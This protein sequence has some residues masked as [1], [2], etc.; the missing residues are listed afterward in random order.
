MKK[1]SL[2]NSDGLEPTDKV[3][4]HGGSAFREPQVKVLLA[5][6]TYKN[7]K[8]SGSTGRSAAAASL[9]DVAPTVLEMAG[10]PQAPAD[11]MSLA[12]V[13]SGAEE[14]HDGRIRYVESSFFPAA[15]NAVRIDEGEV[16][17]ETARM[18]RFTPSGRVQV[19]DDFLEYQVRFR[20]RAVFLNEWA[21][22]MDESGQGRLSL[23]DR[24]RRT[25]W[26]AEDFPDN[27][28]IS[29]L[30]SALCAHWYRDEV[31]GLACSSS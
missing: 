29:E 9:V 14:V 5:I 23:I 2:S 7:G 22:V 4:G 18:Y 28:P 15:L 10:F 20:Q 26:N 19:R 11:G 31:V 12:G 30:K 16:L 3:R 8:L 17:E 27:A 24:E 21:L 25:W 13:I 6:Q 1:D